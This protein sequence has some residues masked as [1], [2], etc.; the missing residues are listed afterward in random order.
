ML[1]LIVCLP[2]F[3][4]K[5]T[6]E[7]WPGFFP[8]R[9]IN[10][11]LDLQGGSY[12]LLEVGVKSVLDEQL[13]GVADA[14]RGELRKAQIRFTEV[15]I[16]GGEVVIA[17][18]DAKDAAA[19]AD[20]V[21]K[22]DPN[23]SVNVQADNTVHA[24]F[25][26]VAL[27]DRQKQIIEQSIEIIRRRIDESGTKELIVQRQGS[28]RIL[29]QIPGLGDPERVKNLIGQTAKLEFR[30]LN[31]NVPL[32]EAMLNGAPP[33][34]EILPSKEKGSGVDRYVVFKRVVVGGESLTNA[35]PQ[36]DQGRWIVQFR[37]DSAG[38]RR[39][40]QATTENVHKRLAIVLDRQV[41]SAPE[42]QTAI[43][44]GNGQ[45]S[46]NFTAQGATD[47]AL[48]LRAGALPAPLNIIEQRT[49]GPDLGADSI[50]AGIISIA[51]AA[52]LV[53]V[54][55]VL[56]YGLFGLFA[57]IAL[58]L[59]VVLLLATLTAFGATLTLPGIAGIVL[60]MGMAVDANVLIYERIREEQRNGRSMLAAVD[61]GFR[62]AMATI[63]DAN[64][65]HLIASLILF[66]LGTGP[67]KGFAVALG[68]GIITSFFTA[69]MV[70]RLIVI[71]WLN[72]ARP[73]KLLV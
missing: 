63:I 33:N 43:C 55:M 42:I 3:F 70:T 35:S 21:R 64:M 51:V 11:G 4:P 7:K 44:G 72:T 31:E 46:G 18:R 69:V 61:T 48:L 57:D 25:S 45:I 59:N 73:R 14:L 10:L 36:N 5:S 58:T 47:L 56:A 28:D 38:G 50:R 71:T 19:A 32:T 6:V 24:V 2:N 1:G 40:C 52:A 26:E 9:Q 12:F 13:N 54:Y 37:F 29:L 67:V 68:V 27:R 60:T 53:I 17:L 49:V 65:T 22:Q 15:E 20:V 34:S 16:K 8:T 39:F 66:E 23:L 30:L 41:I 62:R